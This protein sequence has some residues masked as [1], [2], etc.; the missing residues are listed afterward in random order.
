MADLDL[1]ALV[2][3]A[4]A[5]ALGFDVAAR[6]LGFNP[7]GEEGGCVEDALEVA[8]G[9]GGGDGGGLVDGE[10]AFNNFRHGAGIEGW[11]K[12][13]ECRWSSQWLI[14]K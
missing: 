4:F 13:G 6:A 2:A 1:D 3:P 12:V 10:E 5:L 7:G 11:W 8:D 14:R 9:L